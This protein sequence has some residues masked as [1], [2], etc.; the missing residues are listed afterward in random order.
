MAGDH[1]STSASLGRPMIL[2]TVLMVLS[3][4]SRV[5]QS[6]LRQGP[7]CGEHRHQAAIFSADDLLTRGENSPP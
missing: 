6:E 5:S 7:R 4:G 1:S 3:R 2:Q